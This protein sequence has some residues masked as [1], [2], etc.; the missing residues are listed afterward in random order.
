MRRREL[1]I[2]AGA[3]MWPIALEA[4]EV[5]TVYRIGFLRNGPVPQPFLKGFQQGLHELGYIE[6]KNINIEYGLA[7][8]AEQLP[9]A[10][11]CSQSENR[12][13]AWAGYP[14]C[15]PRPRRRGD[16]IG[17]MPALLELNDAENIALV[18]LLSRTIGSR[19]RRAFGRCG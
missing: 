18:E 16:R 17:T 3:S 13:R 19:C 1:L 14:G 10:R 2:L 5:G 6:G 7:E 4:R 11:T 12:Q 8:T 15:C 9:E